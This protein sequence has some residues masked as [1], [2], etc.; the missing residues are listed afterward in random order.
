ME[1]V[2]KKSYQIYYLRGYHHIVYEEENEVS[3]YR[4]TALK[5]KEECNE[6]LHWEHNFVRYCKFDTAEI[7]S[8]IS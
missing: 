6:M 2:I 4:L 5:R 8:G 3:F 1:E 7:R